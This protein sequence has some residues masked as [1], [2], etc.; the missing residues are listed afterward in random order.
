VSLKKQYWPWQSVLVVTPIGMWQWSRLPPEISYVKDF[1]TS[2]TVQR[3]SC[4]RAQERFD[5]PVYT[6]NLYERKVVKL[7]PVLQKLHETNNRDRVCSIGLIYKTWQ[8]QVVRPVNISHRSLLLEIK[9]QYIIAIRYRAS[10]SFSRKF[11]LPSHP[12][13]KKKLIFQ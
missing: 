7:R 11:C 3:R 6:S 1:R 9:Q 13:L 2:S 8:E 5:H 12:L 10:I 4:K